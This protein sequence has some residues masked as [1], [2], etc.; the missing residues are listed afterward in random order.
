LF[1]PYSGW[2]KPT[3]LRQSY[4]ELR[5]AWDDIPACRAIAEQLVVDS[6]GYH[7]LGASQL[8]KHILGLKYCAS[9]A[10]VRLL[11]LYLDAVGEEAAQHRQEIGQ[12]QEAIAGD[13]VKFVPIP[14]QDFILK[15]I[16]QVRTNHL[17][18]VDYLAE[19][20]L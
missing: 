10:K 8:L 17:E 12:F 13:P 5:E 20:Y 7:R 11:Y 2:T 4:L 3:L 19:R 16:R 6:A 14:V 9:T 15:A 1:E 18:Y